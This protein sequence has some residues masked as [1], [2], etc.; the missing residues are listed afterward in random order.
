MM[1]PNVER[2]RRDAFG[3]NVSEQDNELTMIEPI[4]I[5][6]TPRETRIDDTGINFLTRNFIYR[7][8]E[9]EHLTLLGR[10]RTPPAQNNRRRRAVKAE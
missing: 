4:N 10:E 2:K 6:M 3:M 9:K 1:E 5:G 7:L 8:G